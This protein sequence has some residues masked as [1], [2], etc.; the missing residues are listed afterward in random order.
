MALHQV[1]HPRG[2]LADGP[3]LTAREGSSEYLVYLVNQAMVN[4]F[5]SVAGS[6]QGQYTIGWRL[7]KE[8]TDSHRVDPFLMVP[9]EAWHRD[10]LDRLGLPYP[11]VGLPCLTQWL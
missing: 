7:F 8:F 11:V 2:F 6:T 1:A 3:P 5:N 9:F 10:G 4:A